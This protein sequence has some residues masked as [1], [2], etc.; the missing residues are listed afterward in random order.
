[1]EFKLSSHGGNIVVKRVFIYDILENDIYVAANKLKQGTSEFSKTE[2]A[3]NL[4]GQ[5]WD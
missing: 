2:W 5:E 1:M 4:F 3:V